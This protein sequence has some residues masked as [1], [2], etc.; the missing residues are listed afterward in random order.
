LMSY[1]KQNSISWSIWD[2]DGG[3]YSVVV[4]GTTQPKQPLLSLLK[5]DMP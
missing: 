4:P 1:F 3:G 2:Y 5:Q